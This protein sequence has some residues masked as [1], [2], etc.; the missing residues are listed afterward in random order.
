MSNPTPVAIVTLAGVL[1]C[2]IFFAGI[3]LLRKRPPRA[4]DAKRD[5]MA[6]LGILLQI[7]GY[8]LVSFQPPRQPFLPPVAALEGI[9]GV[10]FGAFTIGV[11]AASGALIASSVRTLGKQWAIRAR[12]VEGHQ[13][14]TEGPYSYVR[15]PIYTGMLGM[16]IATGLA[17]EHWLGLI[18]AVPIFVAGMAI[19]IRTEEKL[20]RAEFGEQFED[21]AKRVPAV[22]PWIY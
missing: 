18:I 14:I 16:L 15:N 17:T 2:W 20:L 4:P 22:I 11:A 8:F 21:Y 3:F 9:A 1:L 5:R 7:C 19:R 10:V 12:L 6:S 13:L